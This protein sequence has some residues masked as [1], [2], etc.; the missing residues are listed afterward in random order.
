MK[1][2]RIDSDLKSGDLVNIYFDPMPAKL[3]AYDTNRE[4]AINKLK[5]ALSK[6]VYLALLQTLF[7]CKTFFRPIHS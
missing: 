5:Y 2:I 1:G 4:K 3:I 6:I 7:Y